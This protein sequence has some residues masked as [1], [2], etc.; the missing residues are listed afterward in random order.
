VTVSRLDRD[1][2]KNASRLSR[3]RDYNPALYNIG[4]VSF[5]LAQLLVSRCPSLPNE[6]FEC[7]QNTVLEAKMP[8]RCSGFR[9]LRQV[10]RLAA[11]RLWQAVSLPVQLLASVS[12]SSGSKVTLVQ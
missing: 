8:C 5:E 1:V 7:T 3:D 11:S 10:I 6:R 4:L 2:H 12:V 9:P